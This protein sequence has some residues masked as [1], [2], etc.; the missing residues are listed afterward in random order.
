[1]IIDWIQTINKNIL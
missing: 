1:M